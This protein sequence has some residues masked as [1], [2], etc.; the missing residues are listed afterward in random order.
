VVAW[1]LAEEDERQKAMKKR[2][3]RIGDQ[4]NPFPFPATYCYFLHFG[5]FSYGF[6]EDLLVR[7][8]NLSLSMEYGIRST[9]EY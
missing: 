7:R 8:V 5:G 9:P 4:F 2:S 3:P 6:E 1:R